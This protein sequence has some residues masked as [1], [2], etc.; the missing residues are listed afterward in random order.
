MGF[1]G[2]SFEEKVEK[3]IQQLQAKGL[4]IAG[5][6]AEVDSDAEVV[7]LCGT[8]PDSAAKGRA[9]SEFNALG[10]TKN[11]FNKI[12]VAAPVAVETAAVAAPVEQAGE[13]GSSAVV[14]GAPEERWHEVV[15]GDTL[16][17][18][19]RKYYGDASK[20]PKIFDANR[21]I[22]DNPDRID[23]GQKLRVPE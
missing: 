20:Y 23:V 12:K 11:T 16:G 6:R 3:A 17:A 14:S 10:E 8:C 9:M 19:A 4:G 1:F 22:L 13:Q 21:D 18:I 15:S 2:K 5:L 7:T